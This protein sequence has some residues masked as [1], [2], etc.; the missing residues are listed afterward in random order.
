M[1]LPSASVSKTDHSRHLRGSFL[2]CSV[3][4]H[5][6]G[7]NHRRQNQEAAPEVEHSQSHLLVSHDH[8]QNLL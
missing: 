8:I 5:L 2:L 7:Q 1:P 4:R 6:F 3:E